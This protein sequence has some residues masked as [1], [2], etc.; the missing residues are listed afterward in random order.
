MMQAVLLVFSG[1]KWTFELLLLILDLN[2]WLVSSLFSFLFW[3]VHFIW[4]LPVL[5]NMGLVHTWEVLLAH[6]ARMG[7]SCYTMVLSTL[8]TTS[9]ALKGC[10]AG[11][12]GLQLVWNLLCH[13]FLRTKEIMQRGLLNI[14]L[15]GQTIQR[16]VWEVLTIAASL[17][18]YLVNSLVN[19][20]LIAMQNVFSSVLAV[21]T[22]LVHAIVTLEQLAIAVV[23][24]LSS[25]AVAVAIL[26]WSP[27][28]HALEVVASLSQNLG[29]II[30]KDLYMIPVLVLLILVWCLLRSPATPVFQQFCDTMSRLYQIFRMFVF[31][32]INSEIWT[33][34]ANKYLQLIRISRTVMELAW[35]LI[36]TR[37]QNTQVRP[38]TAQNNNTRSIWVRNRVPLRIQNPVP[39]PAQNPIHV[40]VQDPV[41]GPS[42][43]QRKPEAPKVDEHASGE[44]PW[45]LL[46]QQEESK[47]C[48]ICQDENKTILLLPCRHLCLCA[49]CNH[50]LLQ[51]PILQRNCPLCR[52]M[53]LQSLNVYI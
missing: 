39:R 45:K 20:C 53:I 37:P 28:Q 15:S 9:N 48:V 30:I 44:D 49:A 4:N 25:N 13:L 43:S 36:R 26:L 29:I 7:D 34:A 40:P 1:L 46:Q 5:I 38:V 24:Q 42:G 21:W 11:L 35:N 41:P 47:K 14:A 51:Q 32:L 23:S 10:L 17:G 16:Q 27:C 19:I 2:Y 3:T 33:W 31:V 18:A 52:K 6:I 22:N 50:I 8:Q 12:D